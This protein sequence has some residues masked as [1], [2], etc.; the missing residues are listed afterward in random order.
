MAIAFGISRSVGI[1]LRGPAG[2]SR[3]LE[4]FA[5]T[6]RAIA[7]VWP[8]AICEARAGAGRRGRHRLGG[9]MSWEDEKEEWEK[10]T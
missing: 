5:S 1:Q 7:A 4:G 2:C 3:A 6:V 8:G 10:N 9:G